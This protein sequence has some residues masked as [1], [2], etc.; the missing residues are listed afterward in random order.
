MC[1]SLFYCIN[2]RIKLAIFNLQTV[3]KP[4]PYYFVHAV[5]SGL[6][7]QQRKPQRSNFAA[8]TSTLLLEPIQNTLFSEYNFSYLYNLYNLK[9]KI[10]KRKKQNYLHPY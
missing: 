6:T 1:R 9:T 2:M 8:E 5:W 3:S 7:L 4:V 10:S